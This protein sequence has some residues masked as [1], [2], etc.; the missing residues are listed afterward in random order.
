MLKKQKIIVALAALGLMGFIGYS[1]MQQTAHEY[2]VC[3]NFKGRAQCAK[4]A[5][6]TAEEAINTGHQM[7]CALATNGR[8]EN[9]ACLAVA[10]ASTR[11]VR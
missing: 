11:R 1:M 3:V 9:M 6:R 10:P 8:D 2:E 7:S 4:A 5:G